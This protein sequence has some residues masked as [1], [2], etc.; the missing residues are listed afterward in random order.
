MQEAIVLVGGKGTRLRPLTNHTPKPLLSVAGTSFIRHQI[1]KLMDAG[2][3]HVVFATS[4]LAS[5]FEEEFQD[6]SQD[7]EISYAVEEVP[8]GTGGAI[9]NAGRLLRGTSADAPVLILNGDILSGVDLRAVLD[10]HQDREADVTLH[11]TR[12][13]DP[14]A[15][16]LVP[17]DDSDRV[18][19]FLEKPKTPEEC[20]TDQINAGCYVFRRSVLDAI[21]ADREVSVEQ[22]TFP[23]LVAAGRRV[24][25]HTTEDYW[26]DL[27]TPLAFVRGSADL[28]TGRTTSPLVPTHGDALIHRTATVDPTARVTGGSTIG[29]GAVVGPH[30]VID[31][32]IIGANVTVAEAARIH[33][34]V[35]DHDSSIGSESFLREVVVGCHSHVG[36]QNELPAQLR[37]SCGIRIPAQ[38]VRVS[39]T[40]VACPTVH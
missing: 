33:E 32:S 14:R 8:L 29:P 19:S 6:F 13:P 16:G 23:Q 7:L 12:V 1:A 21:P 30:A 38:G 18:L 35:V 22:E 34:S 24:F 4:Y 36:A 25:G 28:V 17:T 3:E 40:A 9:R 37:L 26:R 39:G 20:V 10:R 31:R 11:L 27:G 2:V 5:L 15:F